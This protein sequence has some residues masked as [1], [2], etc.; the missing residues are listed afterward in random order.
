MKLDRY[1]GPAGKDLSPEG[2]PF[3]ERSL[4]PEVE[5]QQ[6]KVYSV[7]KPIEVWGGKISRWYGQPGGGTQFYLG[8]KSVQDLIDEGYLEEVK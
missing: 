6:R 1:G 7:L 5:S 2:T 3:E 8:D 4:R